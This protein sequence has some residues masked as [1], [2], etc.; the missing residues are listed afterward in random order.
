MGR[1]D[2]HRLGLLGSGGEF[3]HDRGEHAHPAPPFPTIVEYPS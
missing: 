1:V 3:R 2:H